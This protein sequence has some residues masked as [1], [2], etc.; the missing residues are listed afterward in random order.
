MIRQIKQ[1]NRNKISYFSNKYT[2]LPL[3]CI[4]EENLEQKSPRNE[5]NSGGRGWEV[6]KKYQPIWLAD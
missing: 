2:F 4:I 5:K 3:H 6:I 1:K